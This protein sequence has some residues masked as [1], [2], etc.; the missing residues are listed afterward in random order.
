MAYQSVPSSEYPPL[1][2]SVVDGDDNA[3]DVAFDRDAGYKYTCLV[4]S[5]VLPC[6]F[7]LF[8]LCARK[9]INAQ[10]CK[11]TDRRV[12]FESGWLN[13]SHKSIP[14][15]RIQD[16]NVQQDCIQKCFG[17]QVIDIQTAGM[18][19]GIEP[20]A[21]LI[22]PQDAA[23]VRD[24]IMDRRDALVLG[25]PNSLASESPGRFKT[26]KQAAGVDKTENS[27]IVEELR[28]IKH[29][30]ARLETQVATGVEQLISKD[31]L[32]REPS[33]QQCG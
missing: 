31:Q 30:L 5:V 29:S 28:S 8:S 23:M 12:E 21:R 32:Q 7:P 25:H 22:A 6:L 4:P 13:H 11:I 3:H 33:G 27:A 26:G 17:V 14:L 18:G 1:M 16:V 15:D 10:K 19:G 2:A 24:I 9:N 20:E